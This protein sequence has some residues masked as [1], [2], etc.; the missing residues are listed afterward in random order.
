M[1]KEHH[2]ESIIKY[3]INKQI[4]KDIKEA[5]CRIIVNY[6]GLQ[7]VEVEDLFAQPLKQD[8]GD[9]KEI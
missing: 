3:I 4:N 7:V 1:K 9:K 8:V 5:G 2:K 6:F